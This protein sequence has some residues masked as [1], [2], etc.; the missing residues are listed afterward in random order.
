MPRA[1]PLVGSLSVS[2]RVRFLKQNGRRSFAPL[3]LASA[4][5]NGSLGSL[6]IFP[7]RA[8]QLQES[9]PGRVEDLKW[10]ESEDALSLEW[11]F[12]VAREAPPPAPVAKKFRLP[13]LGGGR[14]LIP[15]GRFLGALKK[16]GSRPKRR[17]TVDESPDEPSTSGSAETQLDVG[18]PAPV[19]EKGN[20]ALAGPARVGLLGALSAVGAAFGA[21]M[22][23]LLSPQTAPFV[24]ALAILSAPEKLPGALRSRFLKL[25][26]EVSRV[27]RP[28]RGP[29][30]G[31]SFLRVLLPVAAPSVWRG[32]SYWFEPARAAPTEAACVPSFCPAFAADPRY[33][34][35]P[36]RLA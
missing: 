8:Y 36:R 21:T 4:P 13:R 20:S 26:S 33:Q 32:V 14:S 22:F 34:S 17:P 1:R 25:P 30:I 18:A 19:R 24:G 12:D 15:W 23:C 29:A 9:S 35:R 16:V 2:L 31:L 28:F 6:S 3:R 11:M 27:L 10:D 7:T 5:R